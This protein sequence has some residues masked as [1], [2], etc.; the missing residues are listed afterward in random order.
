MKKTLSNKETR[1]FL[2]QIK[3]KYNLEIFSKKDSMMLEDEK[4]IIVNNETVFFYH[5]DILIPALKL[6]LKD[7]FLPKVSIDMNA[8]KFIAGGADVMRPGIKHSEDFPKDAII[9]IVDETHKRPLAVG[10]AL[11]SSDDLMKQ[12]KGR[13]IKNLHYI[14]DEAWNK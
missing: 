1:T 4:Y 14:G 8:V 10:L 7:N 12:E 6:L 5:E 3:E 9:S 13:V 2:Q 11:L